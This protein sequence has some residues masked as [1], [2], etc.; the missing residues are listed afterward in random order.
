MKLPLTTKPQQNGFSLVEVMVAAS[1]SSILISASFAGLAGMAKLQARVQ[2]RSEATEALGLAKIDFR[3]GLPVNTTTAADC[4]SE[5]LEE[6]ETRGFAHLE[7]TCVRGTQEVT[8]DG[9]A[10]KEVAPAA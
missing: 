6:D 7:T 5:I 3:D 8:V 2:L 4:T 10:F 1:M 9:Y